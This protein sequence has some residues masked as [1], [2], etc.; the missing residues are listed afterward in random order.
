[1]NARYLIFGS[2]AAMLVLVGALLLA[3][4]GDDDGTAPETTTAPAVTEPGMQDGVTDTL[5]DTLMADSLMADSLLDPD[6]PVSD[7]NGSP[8][9]PATN[10]GGSG[11]GSPGSTGNSGSGAGSRA[12]S[13]TAGASDGG[14]SPAG[15]RDPDVDA[16]LRA[17][18]RRYENVR[19]MQADFQQVID[20]PLLGR[21]TRSAGTLYQRQ[22]DLFLMQFSDPEGDV[23]V[24]DGDY[25]WIYYPSVDPRQVMRSAR[26][27]QGLDLR[28]Q[29]IGDP[30]Q[31]FETEY[32]GR[33]DVR[34]RTA[35]VVTMVPREALGYRHLKVWIDAED[36][37]VRRFELTEENS[38]VRR[39]EL[40]DLRINPTLPDRLF[41][42]DPPANAHVVTR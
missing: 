11:A 15:A 4:G 7:D 21:Q 19:S 1:M 31:R 16:I 3:G 2:L 28:S 8:D 33:E 18:S 10:G 12:V 36:H 38:N 41:R 13:G 25:F 34:G 39:F 9:G 17:T 42:F 32:H 24:S 37:L 6:T 30:T 40:T 26:G 14:A 5:A 29:F 27:A 23:V 22:P 35:H 20:N